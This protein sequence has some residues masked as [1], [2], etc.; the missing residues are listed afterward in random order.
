[1]KIIINEKE[2]ERVERIAR[3][4][5]KIISNIRAG[6]TANEI[7]Q[8][9]GCN[10]SVASYYIRLLVKKPKVDVSEYIGKNF[11]RAIKKLS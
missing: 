3:N 10:H 6:Y 4:T 9:V 1:M 2:A 8:R 7:V 11:G 5:I